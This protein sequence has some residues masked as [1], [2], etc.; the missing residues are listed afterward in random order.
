MVLAGVTGFEPAHYGVKVRCVT[1]SLH[2]YV[3]SLA[4]PIPLR[5]VKELA[6]RIKY[7]VCFGRTMRV[8]HSTVIAVSL[9]QRLQCKN[10]PLAIHLST[11]HTHFFMRFCKQIGRRHNYSTSLL[12]PPICRYFRRTKPCKHKQRPRFRKRCRCRKDVR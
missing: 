6:P 7:R 5:G 8:L 2:P 10:T 4:H 9:R 1:A 3:F 12:S 11:T